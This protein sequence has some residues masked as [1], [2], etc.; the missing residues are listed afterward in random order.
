M[1][2]LDIILSLFA[3]VILEIILGIDNLVFLS[4]L[5]E[6]L[7]REQRKKARRWGLTFAWM[8]RLLLL[9]FAVWLVKLAKPFVTV[10]DFSYSIRDLF[11]LV[12]GGFLIAK[13]TQEI[14]YEVG[15]GKTELREKGA[16]L[17][18]FKGVVIQVAL[19]DIIFSLDSVL[20]AVGLTARYWVMALAIT[21]AILVMIYASE[22]VSQFIEKYPTV[23]MLALSFLILIGMILVADSFSFHVPRG[24]VYF[25][26]GFSLGVEALNLLRHRKLNKTDKKGS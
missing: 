23:K 13:A 8:T 12:G 3:L 21:C 4:I 24:Y 18:T 17:A 19:M 7:P 16:A 1:E 9:A 6:K 22:P 20:T 25:A 15:D 26:M 14:H 2:L 10:G 11:L 5:T